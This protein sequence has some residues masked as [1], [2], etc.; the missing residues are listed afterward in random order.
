[1]YSGNIW[2]TTLDFPIWQ[3]FSNRQEMVMA[4]WPNAS[5]A[6]GTI[7]N[8]ENHWGHGTIDEDE[9]AYTN[10][11]LIDEPVSYTHLTLPTT[12]YV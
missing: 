11:M 3:L 1:M 10:G 6:D 5:F 7:W 12:P 8:K 9:N 2:K 4:R